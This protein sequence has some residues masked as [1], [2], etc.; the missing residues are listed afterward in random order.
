MG[1]VRRGWHRELQIGQG[2]RGAGAD[3]ASE[4]PVGE[5]RLTGV[6]LSS[7]KH[8]VATVHLIFFGCPSGQLRRYFGHSDCRTRHFPLPVHTVKSAE[9]WR[10]GPV[11]KSERLKSRV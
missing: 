1:R 6:R 5:N 4:A 2:L 8:F 9:K 7:K 11:R 3:L 10:F